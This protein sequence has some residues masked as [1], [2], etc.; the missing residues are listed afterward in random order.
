MLLHDPIVTTSWRAELALTY[1]R[2][3]ARTVLATR[4]HDGP[5]VVQK[6]LYPEG[7]EICH[8]ILIHPPAG[9]ASGDELAIDTRL[10]AGS[11]VLLT[12]PGA[13]KWY[14]SSGPFARQAFDFEVNAGAVLE[15]LPQES[16]FFN[17]TRADLRLDVSLAPDAR[18][19]GWDLFCFGRTASR[20]RF[21]RGE[22]RVSTTILRDGKPIWI[23]RGIIE[24]GN[25]IL[26]AASGLAGEPVT[27]TLIAA[28]DTLTAEL[29]RVCRVPRPRIGDGA[30]TLLPGILVARYLGPSTEAARAYFIELWTLI[31][32]ALLACE[33]TVPRIWRT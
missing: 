6:P 5:L 30:V 26:A 28:A 1:E 9:M 22:C 12:T 4:R 10:G 32:P 21:E 11:H 19:I 16:I 13:G 18:F 17:D 14:R 25:R 20:E 7:P 29:V 24:G 33:A 23:E 8:T 31:R 15:W 27:G 3:D 2:R